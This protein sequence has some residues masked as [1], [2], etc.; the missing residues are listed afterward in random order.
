MPESMKVNR[1][2]SSAG[3]KQYFSI[4]TEEMAPVWVY[5]I[6]FLL[7]TSISNGIVLIKWCLPDSAFLC[8]C[9]NT[10]VKKFNPCK[11]AC[12]GQAVH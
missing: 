9:R 5:P 4:I 7:R 2:R 10:S 12:V 8:S 3:V 6:V 1:I 11:I